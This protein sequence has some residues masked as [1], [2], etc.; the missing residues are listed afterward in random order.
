MKS[1][2]VHVKQAGAMLIPVAL[3]ATFAVSP[4]TGSAREQPHRGRFDVRVFARIMSPGSPEPI[5]TGPDGRVYVGTNQQNTANTT[6]PSKVFVFTPSGKLVRSFTLKGQH[7]GSAHGIQGLAFDRDGLLYV[8][9]RAGDFSRIV[10][11]DPVTG[12]QRNYATFH[13]VPTCAAARRTSDCSATSSDKPPG[14]DNLVFAPHGTLY[15]TDIDQGLIWRVSRGGGKAKVWFTDPRFD[16]PFGVNDIEFMADGKTLLF[17]V[18]FIAPVA[19]NH[20]T[21][22]LFKLPVRADG[23]PG[24]MSLFWRTH[25]GDGPE[26]PAI[27]RSGSVYLALAGADQLVEISP[28]GHEL[29]RIPATPTENMRLPVPFDGPATVVF[30]GDRLLVT[31][32]SFPVSHPA[33]WAVF[34]IFVGEPGLPLY[35]PHMRAKRRATR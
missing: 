32:Q 18:T 31:N 22:G 1:M 30:V 12:R 3:A 34:D 14:P 6:V 25:P 9:D 8:L 19:A 16:S 2:R 35:R 5:A 15:V 7:L 28:Q 4:S 10:T 24:Q 21:G 29:A 20:G 33:H 13:D 17:S 11:I 27:A 26:S 23:R